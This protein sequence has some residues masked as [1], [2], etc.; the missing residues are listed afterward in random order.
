VTTIINIFA[1]PAEA[2]ASLKEKS[3]FLAALL[4]I[5]LAAALVQF[6]YFSGVDIAW[7]FEEQ[8]LAN[9]NTTQEQ[10]EQTIRFMTS[11][12]Q[13]GLAV[14]FALITAFFV[15]V[16][17]LIQALYFK[18]A[19]QFTKDGLSYKRLFTLVC[20]AS[21]P[22]LL[23]SIASMVKVLTSD[24]SLMSATELNP[25]AFWELLNLE[26]MG[27]GT[28][29]GIVMNTDPMTIWSLVLLILGYKIF[30]EKDWA[31]AVIIASIPT[32]LTFGL[33]F[34]F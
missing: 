18:I 8:M 1:S 23:T 15:T 13:S 3:R 21:M 16:V 24:V 19:S 9:P 14:V 4:L 26:P 11:I 10:V 6:L 29:D 28:L 30:S 2:F 33:A 25:L 34:I 20:W 32:A 31:T 12:P 17:F 22:G 5:V 7:F 27:A